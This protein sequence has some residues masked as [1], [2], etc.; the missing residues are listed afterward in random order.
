L[1]LT[2]ATLYRYIPAARTANTPGVLQL[3]LYP[4]DRGAPEGFQPWRRAAA[5]HLVKKGFLVLVFDELF[6]EYINKYK[7]QKDN[8]TDATNRS[9]SPPKNWQDFERISYDIYSR[10]WQT[11]DAEMHG[12]QGQPQAGVDIYGHDRLEKKFVGVQCKGKDQTYNE[13]LTVTELRQEVEKAKTFRPKLDVFVLATTASN[14]FKIQELARS[15]TE[16]HE[17][18]GLFEVRVQGWLTLQQWLTDYPDLLTKHFKDLFP[19]SE[20]LGGIERGIEATRRE[21]AETRTQLA[22]IKALLTTQADQAPPSDPLA[23]RIM[24]ASRLVDDGLA[25]GALNALDRIQKE[26]GDKVSGRNL[27]RLRAGVGFAQVALGDLPAAVKDFRDAYAAAPNWSNARAI[28]ALAELLDGDTASAYS[29]ASEVLTEDQ[30]SYHA[31]AVVIDTAPPDVTVAE[32]EARVPEGLRNR[33][34]I[35]TRIPRMIPHFA[36]RWS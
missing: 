34:D 5:V 27:F 19:P 23:T 32:L 20:I 25:K 2:D 16:A 6:D 33:V 21:G 7:Y 9:L 15:I 8:M 28:L 24:A 18:Q 10:R 31:A 3:T 13:P 17:Q 26:E 4:K 36:T 29:R 11:N 12:R 30:T 35:L 14:D 22:D 1:G